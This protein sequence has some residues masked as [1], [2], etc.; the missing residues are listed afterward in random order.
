MK[1]FLLIFLF[2]IFSTSVFAQSNRYI[3]FDNRQICEKNKGVWRE[4]GD[5]CANSCENKFDEYSICAK[6]LTYSCDCGTSRCWYKNECIAASKYKKIYDEEIQKI[7][8]ELAKKREER[9]EKSKNDPNMR[10]YL[11]NLYGQKNS[12]QNLANQQ[13]PAQSQIEKS[14]IITPAPQQPINQIPANQM[15]VNQMQ[16]QQPIQQPAQPQQQVMPDQ[17]PPFFLQQEQQK[18]AQNPAP[19]P[20]VPLEIKPAND[21]SKGLP[22]G[23]PEIPLPA[24]Y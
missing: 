20:A 17:V 13:Q 16:V 9:E 11:F 6:A 1:K 10:N 15:P 22:A 2:Y 19:Q 4:F 18:Q 7:N 3:S 23:L 12:T 14:R 5:A 24:A 8:K 21:Q